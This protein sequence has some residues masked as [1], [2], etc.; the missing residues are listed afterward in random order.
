MLTVAITNASDERVSAYRNLKDVG[1]RVN[2]CFIAESELVLERVLESDLEIVSAFVTDQRY[3]RLAERFAGRPDVAV[4]VAAPPVLDGVVGFP[5]H[6]GVLALVRR[7]V[8]PSAD[9]LVR[10]ASRVVVLE[11]VVDPDNV[12]SIFRHAAAFGADAV[13]LSL[14]A[15]DP[16]YRKA[17]RTSMGRVLDVPYARV[18]VHEDLLD[19]LRRNG[20]RSLA[21]TP[22]GTRDLRDLGPGLGT[23]RVATMFGAEASG[24]RAATI[25]GADWSVRIPIDPAI[26]SLNVATAAAIAMY[27]L[28][29]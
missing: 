2:G 29:R 9:V 4:F 23:V 15:G 5:M 11:D 10:S 28:F 13:L 16:L 18:G 25:D 26:D 27:E 21:L 22:R 17:V 7:P 1:Q 14:Q 3:G 20:L 19:V 12:G 8:L 24:L 6:R